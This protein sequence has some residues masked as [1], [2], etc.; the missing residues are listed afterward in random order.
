MAEEPVDGPLC[1]GHPAPVPRPRLLA[2]RPVC[3]PIDQ[4]TPQNGGRWVGGGVVVV[5]VC[6]CVYVVVV[7]CVC[8]GGGGLQPDQAPTADAYRLSRPFL[9]CFPPSLVPPPTWC[10]SKTICSAREGMAAGSRG[11]AGGCRVCC[12]VR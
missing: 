2:C 5:V 1:P 9:P 4:V 8:G 6:V 12:F 7:G 3:C 10:S 11:G